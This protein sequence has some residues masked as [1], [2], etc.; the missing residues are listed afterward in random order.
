MSC[1]SRAIFSHETSP[2][3]QADVGMLDLIPVTQCKRTENKNLLVVANLY[4]FFV[5]QNTKEDMDE[6]Q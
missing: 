4:H 2:E 3:S 5:L 6:C 1:F